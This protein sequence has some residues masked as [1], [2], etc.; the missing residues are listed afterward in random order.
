MA[1]IIDVRNSGGDLVVLG[2]ALLLPT[3]SVNSSDRLFP[4]ALRYNA[5]TMNVEMTVQAPGA[6]AIVWSAVQTAAS[7]LSDL[8]ERYHADASY[9]RGTVLVIGGPNEVTISTKRYDVMVAGIVSAEAAY[10]MNAAAGDDQTHPYVA[11]KGRVLCKVAGNVKK[12]DFL[13]TS[14]VPG[15]AMKVTQTVNDRA[16]IG[17]ALHDF[18]GDSGTVEVKV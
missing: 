5:S 6:T 15:H 11:L 3:S 18:V 8:A 13:A 10:K 7:P 14:D 9:E 2:S 4:G 12:G 16:V 1:H 17:V